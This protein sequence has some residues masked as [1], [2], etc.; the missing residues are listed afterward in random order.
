[1]NTFPAIAA[2]QAGPAR[3]QQFTDDDLPDGDVTVGVR[4]SS[5]NYKDGLAVTGKGKIL[6]SYPLVC[7]IDL[8][9][10]VEASD[11]PHWSVGDAV[12]VTGW[13]L[14]ETHPGGFT[15]RQRVQ[16]A[17]LTARPETLTLQQTMA[18]GTAGLTAM[19]CVLALEHAGLDL[20]ALAA[21]IAPAVDD[22]DL[23]RR[24][25]YIPEREALTGEGSADDSTDHGPAAWLATGR[26]I[27]SATLKEHLA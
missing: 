21:A 14:S 7:G 17:W 6:R 12:L 11:S 24:L 13:G 9:G 2:Q 3:L 4:Y 23:G 8:A 27:D 19:L 26:L 18:I 20:D 15:Q 16:S 1:M 22:G 5:L 10:V 25:S